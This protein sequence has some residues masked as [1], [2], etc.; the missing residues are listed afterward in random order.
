MRP[1]FYSP[2]PKLDFGIKYMVDNR[3]L[4]KKL[5]ALSRGEQVEF[6]D[7]EKQQVGSLDEME[8]DP[9]ANVQEPEE[10]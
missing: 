1:V 2:A 10:I 8:T 5:L 6:T 3:S 4:E 9:A 7:E